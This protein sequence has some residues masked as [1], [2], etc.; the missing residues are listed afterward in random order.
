MP[1]STFRMNQ[2]TRFSNDLAVLSSKTAS[3]EDKKIAARSLGGFAAEMSTFRLVKL[4]IG[5][6]VFYSIAQF[7]RGEEDDEEE[8]KKKW[9]NMV[10]GA[11]TSVTT[12]VL[13]PAPFADIVAR[14]GF[15]AV[16]DKVQEFI[17]TEEEDRYNIFTDQGKTV[18]ESFIS[19]LGILG[20]AADKAT[21]LYENI[22]LGVTGR[23]TDNYGNEKTIMEKDRELLSNPLYIALGIT[24]T[25]GINPFSPETNNVMNTIVKSAKR[26]AMTGPQLKEYQETGR[27]KEEAKKYKAERKAM[28]EEAYGGYETLEEF[29]KKEPEKFDEYS[30]RGG[31]LYNYR[32]SERL[33]EEEKN[34]DKPFRGLSEE[35]FK[36]LYPTEWKRDYGPG[37]RYFRAQRTPEALRKKA[38]KKR[39]EAKRE[40]KKKQAEDKRKRKE[41]LAKRR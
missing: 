28:K 30:T 16:L 24:T 18:F 34:K 19:D 25:I 37:T 13:S 23:F 12:D 33:E 6:Y 39:A 40:I 15:S 32:E 17:G 1:L 8:K 3:N 38:E 29:E 4:Y 26:D 41:A 9:D 2:T 22:K 27:D 10:K 20:I 7:I 11:A 14:S 5:Y 31:K 21:K 36:E 35:R